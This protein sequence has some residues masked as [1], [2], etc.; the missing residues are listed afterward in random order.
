MS[1]RGR[2]GFRFTGVSSL[3]ELEMRL[4]KSNSSPSL[5]CDA[6]ARSFPFRELRGDFDGGVL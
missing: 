6:M 4:V 1:L 2:P 3:S 5:L